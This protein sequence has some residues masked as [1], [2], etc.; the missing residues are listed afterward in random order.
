MM[1]IG[2]ETQAQ[3][4]LPFFKFMKGGLQCIGI[5]RAIDFKRGRDGIDRHV[6]LHALQNPKAGLSA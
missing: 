4:M 6:G 5:N 1:G 2:F 3:R